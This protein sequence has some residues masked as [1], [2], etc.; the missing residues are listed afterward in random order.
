MRALLIVCVIFVTPAHAKTNDM[1]GTACE[2]DYRAM[3][4]Q[5]E[6]IM[7]DW[8][9]Q[10]PY[11]CDKA[12]PSSPVNRQTFEVYVIGSN[13]Y[14]KFGINSTAHQSTFTVMQKGDVPDS[15]GIIRVIE[16]QNNIWLLSDQGNVYSTG[17][18]YA[19]LLG[20]NDTDSMVEKWLPTL[21]HRGEMSE[22]ENIV[23]IYC[24]ENHMMLLTNEHNVYGVGENFYGQLGTG[25]MYDEKYIPTLM[26]RGEIPDDEAVTR[27]CASD[28]HNV[29]L[30]NASNVYV[31]GSGQ[32][33]SPTSMNRGDIP[34]DEMIVDIECTLTGTV[35][36]TDTGAVYSM[37]RN[38]DSSGRYG[39][40]GLPDGVDTADALTF[41]RDGIFNISAGDRH[42]LMAVNSSHV[43]AS[44]LNADGELGVGKSGRYFINEPVN[45][46]NMSNVYAIVQMVAGKTS[47]AFRTQSGNVYVSGSNS[48][49][50]LAQGS[51]VDR[52]YKPTIMST[53]TL[54]T[55]ST[56]VDVHMGYH[57]TLLG[58]AS[59]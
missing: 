26:L 54:P 49:N 18:N 22:T 24:G 4:A 45:F 48:N 11:G 53:D 38:A 7:T 21:M 44:G 9:L 46:D 35:L 57:C 40:I 56:I 17:S 3:L 50:A 41:V 31:T 2:M 1:T 43:Y 42:I 16:S 25:S 58:L 51:T 34:D 37:G 6:R 27:I 28:N 12:Y 47:S 13:A 30:T 32:S 14:G 39:L 36:R 5:Y 20:I 33:S 10:Y 8:C 52:V 29:Y 55:N 23:N 15:E 59:K 19:G